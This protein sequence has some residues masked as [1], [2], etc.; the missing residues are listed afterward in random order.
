MYHAMDIVD[1]AFLFADASQ[2]LLQG[3]DLR[4]II[5]IITISHDFGK[6]TSF[7]QAKLAESVA[8]KPGHRDSRSSHSAVSSL[9]SLAITH[10]Y[11]DRSTA[12]IPTCL[13][14]LIA[15]LVVLK[16][17]GDL[18][19]NLSRGFSEI[20][21]T[22]KQ[23][24]FL[25]EQV[26]DLRLRA[27]PYLESIYDAHLKTIP[28]LAI[29]SFAEVFALASNLAGYLVNGTDKQG[30]KKMLGDIS[31][32]LRDLAKK[33]TTDSQWHVRFGYY[34]AAKLAFSSL[35]EADKL[36]AAFGESA[37]ELEHP[38]AEPPT[39]DLPA[40]IGKFKEEN[41]TT[42]SDMNTLREQVFD[43]VMAHFEHP[44]SP[45]SGSIYTINAPTGS[46]KTLAALSFVST[47]AGET[48]KKGK[49]RS[50]VPRLIYCLPFLSIIDQVDEQLDALL[51]RVTGMDE[52]PSS[53]LLAH[54]HLVKMAYLTHRLDEDVAAIN[55]EGNDA[56]LLISAW[57][58]EVIVTTFH[59]LAATMFSCSNRDNLRFNKACQ[60]IIVLDEIQCFPLRY[61]KLV[62]MAFT[63]L[64]T[65]IG[66]PV[67]LMSATLPA[68]FGDEESTPLLE[69]P[70]RDFFAKLD[71]ISI[72]VDLDE[73]VTPRELGKMVVE[74]AIDGKSCLAVVNTRA[75]ARALH[76]AVTSEIET[77]SS[78][79]TIQ[80]EFLSGDVLVVDRRATIRHV[81]DAI[82]AGR[83]IIVVSTQVIEAGVDLDFNT[84]F[85][86]IA[87]LDSLIQVAGRCNRNFDPAKKGEYHIITMVGQDEDGEMQGP[88]AP[89][90]YDQDL[91]RITS[92]VLR[93]YA[94]R[95]DITTFP[96]NA[97]H[98][99]GST[100]YAKVQAFS[101]T[102]P[103]DQVLEDIA[104]LDLRAIDEHFVMI[105]N[106]ASFPVFLSDGDES[107]ATWLAFTSLG[108]EKNPITRKNQF[109]NLKHAFDQRVLDVR[110]PKAK[111]QQLERLLDLGSISKHSSGIY[112]VAPTQFNQFYD[113]KGFT[114]PDA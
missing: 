95:T 102:H 92:D 71:R 90:V 108:L 23:H 11:L 54:H 81:K 114:L 111:R 84:V 58:S 88:Y 37:G 34:F 45:T 69:N 25:L 72:H 53:L 107:E 100:Y 87:P 113:T 4:D 97:W 24:K 51:K 43:G 33:P 18:D 19:A 48:Q 32:Q 8:G 101:T 38:Y 28:Q 59:Q 29:V 86:D 17:H 52:I 6:A 79:K 50:L 68:I 35:I 49:D 2:T 31:W 56:E 110:I 99:L 61:W 73:Q 57:N 83:P 14:H 30:V 9:F 22:F 104:K 21:D 85:R 27:L 106:I 15:F 75:C 63:S 10:L 66:T 46:G 74:C 89:L 77:N 98:E 39:L 76:E 55:Y 7:F 96:E 109:L 13:C 12:G 47:L 36:N 3:I 42:E 65:L 16:H 105:E 44:A 5:K 60:G 103:S 67:L 64:S 40:A 70:D 78:S 93:D 1:D 91:L 80:V 112:Y 26:E 41:F 62:R 94:G 82:A 20:P